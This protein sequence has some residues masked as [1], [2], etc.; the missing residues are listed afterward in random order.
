VDE[1]TVVVGRITRAHGI[2]GEVAVQVL[3]EVPT[4]FSPGA[5]VYLE[6]GRPL[7]VDAARPH[8][9]RLLVRFRGV[10]DRTRAE[11]L[12]RSMLVV[13]ESSSP[14]L[15]EGSWW[16]HQLVGCRVRTEEGRDLGTVREVMH[17]PAND[18]WAAVDE[19]GTETLVPVLKDVLVSV[20]VAAKEIVIRE[21][22]GLIAPEA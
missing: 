21:V 11:A 13:P 18:V 6:D 2:R 8:G 3:S 4:R 15:P 14:P 22:P 7:E 9:E 19:G 12:A 5:V 17:T 1:P 16:D 10:E 20:D